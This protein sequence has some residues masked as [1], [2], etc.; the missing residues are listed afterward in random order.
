MSVQNGTYTRSYSFE[1]DKDGVVPR[2]EM[3]SK[4]DLVASE[5]EGRPIFHDVEEVEFLIP[6]NPYN[7]H[8]AVVTNEHRQRWPEQYKAFKAGHEISASGTPIEQWGVLN[9]SQRNELK[10]LNLMTVE[11]IAEMSDHVTQRFMGG[12]RLRNM[13]KAYL[14]EAEAGKLLAQATAK[15]ERDDAKIAELTRKV[16]ELSS[17]LNSVHGQMQDLKN[18]PN[19]LATMIPGMSDPIELA[20]QAP[21]A[22]GGSS[23]DN[24]PS[25]PKRGRKPM[26]RDEHGNI[27]RA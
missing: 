14:D 8:A 11:H 19:P 3:K 9:S 2:F 23:L 20:K 1:K 26:P 6:G 27:V 5:R 15:N 21:V 24:L 18:A 25:L 10:A 17:L 22:H 7:I 16:E 12:M 13:A 4:Q